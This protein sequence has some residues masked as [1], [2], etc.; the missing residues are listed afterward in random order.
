MSKFVLL[1][2]CP[3]KKCDKLW[4]Y[5]GLKKYGEVKLVET[6]IPITYF[7]LSRKLS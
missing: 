2:D 1:Y 7:K 3:I 4:L 6:G 5:E